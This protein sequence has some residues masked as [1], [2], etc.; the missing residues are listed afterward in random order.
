MTAGRGAPQRDTLAQ[1]LA[2]VSLGWTVFVLL[3]GLAIG[4]AENWINHASALRHPEGI[5][6]MSVKPATWD[7]TNLWFGGRL[8]LEGRTWV[9]FDVETYRAELRAMFSPRIADSE[10]SYPPLALFF[11]VP[12]ALLP[13]PLAYLLWTFGTLGFLLLAV[14][15]LGLPWPVVLLLA[16]SPGVLLNTLFGQN[17]ALTTGLLTLGLALSASAPRWSGVCFGLLAFKPQIGILAPFALAAGRRWRAFAW[18]AACVLGMVLASMALFGAGAWTGFLTVTRPLM[19][20]I[21][22][23]EFGQPYQA[24]S[25]TVFA[26]LRAL[27]VG[28]GVA[29]GVQAA[30]SAVAVLLTA[31]V[32]RREG[33]DLAL[34]CVTTGPLVLLATPYS[35]GYDMVLLSVATLYLFRRNGCRFGPI[36]GAAWLWPGFNHIWAQDHVPIAPLFIAA[37]AA[38]CLGE[39]VRQGSRGARS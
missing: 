15:R 19:V 38:L 37:V 7:F 28:L 24:N 9:L 36:L 3:A 14:R 39:A 30:V 34:R 33:V 13:L 31:A 16:I 32:W 11:G 5:S 22:E 2:G 20:G 10:W 21:L 12:L 23:A 25:V 18:S 27:G 1:V 29:Y 4:A 17:G 26:T 8:V 6:I 35:F